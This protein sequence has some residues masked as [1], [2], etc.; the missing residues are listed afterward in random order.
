MCNNHY[1]YNGKELDTDFGLNWYHYGFRMCDPA[2][3]RFTGVDP[4]SDQFTH[5]STYNYAE[6]RPIN[7]ID[8]HGLQFY[9]INR[10]PENNQAVKKADKAIQRNLG[11]IAAEVGAGFTPAGVALDIRDIAQAT[12]EGDGVGM[13]LSGI[14]FVPGVGDAFKAVGKRLRGLFADARKSF[15]NIDEFGGG[16]GLLDDAEVVRGGTCNCEQFENGSGVTIDT[17]GKLNGVSVNSMSG[18]SVEEL[19]VGIR[20]GQ[21]GVT[22]VGDVRNAGGNIIPS[23]RDRNPNHATLS[24]ITGKQAEELFKPTIKN[25]SKNK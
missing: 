17:G 24:G 19:S 1:L 3:A 4:I 2:I 11:G 16:R 7:G 21:V 6:N 15:D 20:N 23:P 5:V 8:L 14:G 13:I 18:K 10:T 12:S 25:P 9:P 22:T